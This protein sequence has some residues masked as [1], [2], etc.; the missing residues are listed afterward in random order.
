MQSEPESVLVSRVLMESCGNIT[1]SSL[2]PGPSGYSSRMWIAR[3]DEGALLIR[4]PTVRFKAFSP[5]TPLSPVLV[6]EYRSGERASDFLKK[7]P[8]EPDLVPCYRERVN[9]WLK[10]SP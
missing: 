9:H 7:T 4:I 6:Q 1:V 8:N 2:D 5:D 3:T 10:E